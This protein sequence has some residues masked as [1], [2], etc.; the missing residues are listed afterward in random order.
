MSSIR[1]YCELFKTS[2]PGYTPGAWNV[3]KVLINQNYCPVMLGDWCSR[4]SAI[5]WI[6]YYRYTYPQFEFCLIG[7]EI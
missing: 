1:K 4:E 6:G 5:W 2:R 7:S 3:G